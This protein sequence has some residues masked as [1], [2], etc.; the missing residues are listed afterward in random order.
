[1]PMLTQI[2]TE[3]SVFL[4]FVYQ[5]AVLKRVAA[6]LRRRRFDKCR[7]MCKELNLSVCNV[8]TSIDFNASQEILVEMARRVPNVEYLRVLARQVFSKQQLPYM[9]LPDYLKYPSIVSLL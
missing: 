6:L 5:C 3:N 2:F 9:K 4:F 1:M 7:P 8:D